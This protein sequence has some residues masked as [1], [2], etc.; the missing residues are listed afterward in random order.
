MDT[1]NQIL[2]E[3]HSIGV[4]LTAHGENFRLEPGSQVPSEL[5]D[6]VRVHKGE[7]LAFL[8]SE[9][10]TT[11][12]VPDQRDGDHHA[13]DR[14]EQWIELRWPDGGMSWI[15]PHH[16]GNELDVID[17]PAPCTECGR[18]ELWQSPAGKWR[19]VRCDPP[20]QPRR[21]R[22]M[23]PRHADTCQVDWPA[24]LADFV[25]LLGADDLPPAFSLGPGRVVSDSD[26]FLRWV[27]ADI[28]RGPSGPRA[29]YGALQSDL[30][31]L[32]QLLL[33][34]D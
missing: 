6:R 34:N 29:R 32:R 7:L 22:R 26:K 18:L 27:K 12:D 15:H 1:T 28:R 19:C 13:D 20:R 16:A 33:A 17:P 2:H 4:T 24:A 14:F 25:L 23:P 31:R 9:A 3:L 8:R 21:I 11:D 30:E 10:D 5:A